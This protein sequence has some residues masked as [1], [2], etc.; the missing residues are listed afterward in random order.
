MT[1]VDKQIAIRLARDYMGSGSAIRYGEAFG[2]MNGFPGF[3]RVFLNQRKTASFERRSFSYES[4]Q[5]LCI[6]DTAI[7]DSD[8]E[9]VMDEAELFII[10]DFHRDGMKLMIR[11]VYGGS[12]YAVKL[13]QVDIIDDQVNTM[14]PVLG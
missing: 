5:N 2:T 4:I 9:E 11:E 1:K 12:A 6:K 14:M 13:A 3:G 7:T 10:V 8:I